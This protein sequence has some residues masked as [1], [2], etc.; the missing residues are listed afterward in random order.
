MADKR[1][2]P[3][4]RAREK[5]AARE[6]DEQLL[7]EGALTPAQLQEQNTLLAFP[8]ARVKFRRR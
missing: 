2:N 3:A 8:G 1:Y 6:R 4:E 5:E 7:A